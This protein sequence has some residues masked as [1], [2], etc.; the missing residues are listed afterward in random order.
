[1]AKSSKLATTALFCSLAAGAFAQNAYAGQLCQQLQSHRQ[2]CIARWTSLGRGDDGQAGAFKQCAIVN[3]NAMIAA[4]C[5]T[6]TMSTSNSD[7]GAAPTTMSSSNSDGGAA[8]T[9]MSTSG[10][11]GGPA[12]T[13]MSTS[14][15]YGGAEP[16]PRST[17]SA[18]RGAEPEKETSRDS[19][20]RSYRH[21]SPYGRSSEARDTNTSRTF[22]R[23]LGTA[24]G[25]ARGVSA[26]RSYGTSYNHRSSSGS[27]IYR[28]SPVYRSPPRG[29]TITSRDWGDVSR[30]SG[31]TGT[32]SAK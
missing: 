23:T 10:A 27:E 3:S 30:H 25:I 26:A 1:M 19:E 18:D 20:D 12:P 6:S 31:K 32:M 4:G 21:Y 11:D 9:T 22:T 7:G 2:N 28:S 24:A 8:P 29:S 13:T 17:S 14:D 15:A 5:P 16:T